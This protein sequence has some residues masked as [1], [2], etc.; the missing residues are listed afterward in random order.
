MQEHPVTKLLS[1]WPT[2]QAVHEDARTADAD[3]D[4][5]AVHRWFQRGSIPARYWQALIDG[6]RRRSLEIGADDFVAAHAPERA[7]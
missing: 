3:L 6:A 1:N 2:R 7:A 4:M 5:I